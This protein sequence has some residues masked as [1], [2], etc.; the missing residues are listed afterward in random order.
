[1]NSCVVPPRR[2]RWRKSGVLCSA[3]SEIAPLASQ[4]KGGMHYEFL[5]RSHDQ[6]VRRVGVRASLGGFDARAEHAG[7]AADLPP[8]M[9]TIVGT[10][11]GNAGETATKNVLTLNTIMFDLYGDAAK[12]FTG[13][14]WP[15]IR[16]SSGCSRGR[17]DA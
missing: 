13:T 5:A 9:N 12:I 8:Y 6:T 15:R 16:S 11:P 10:S 1:M 7:S 4:R 2:C 3:A 14:S 17:A